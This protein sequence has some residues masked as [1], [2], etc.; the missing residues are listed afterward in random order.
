MSERNIIPLILTSCVTSSMLDCEFEYSGILQYC[1]LDDENS[2]IEKIGPCLRVLSE[3]VVDDCRIVDIDVTASLAVIQRRQEAS[4]DS[5]NLEKAIMN[6][7]GRSLVGIG[8][9][10]LNTLVS[11]FLDSHVG[12]HT[13]RFTRK[14]N[15]GHATNTREA[16]FSRTSFEKTFLETSV[17]FTSNLPGTKS[18]PENFMV[19]VYDAVDLV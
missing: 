15:M 8:S 14:D 7:C 11:T 9:L 16:A 5:L 1:G 6:R 2:G 17:A 4:I 13:K 10:P 19:V 18:G 3:E 12:S